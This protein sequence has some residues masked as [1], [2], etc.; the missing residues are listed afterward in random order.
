MTQQRPGQCA[1]NPYSYPQSVVDWHFV[2]NSGQFVDLT[3]PVPAGQQWVHGQP[4]GA[5]GSS[6]HTVVA[7]QMMQ[8]CM[9]YL[10]IKKVCVCVCVCV[11]ACVTVQ[12]IGV[13]TC[14]LGCCDSV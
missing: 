1:N 2:V 11:C 6:S 12:C 4:H 13:C 14:F 5:H 9:V 3:S 8:V 7:P 10:A